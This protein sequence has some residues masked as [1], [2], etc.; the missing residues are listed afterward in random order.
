MCG[1]EAP[2]SGR[3]DVIRCAPRSLAL[4]FVRSALEPKEGCMCEQYQ[5]RMFG[6]WHALQQLVAGPTTERI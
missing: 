3:A 4:S 2:F 1:W 5:H 6:P